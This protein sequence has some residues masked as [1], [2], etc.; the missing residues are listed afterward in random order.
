M[1]VDGTF[2]I[3][4]VYLHQETKMDIDFRVLGSGAQEP[5]CLLSVGSRDW[6][7]GS[8]VI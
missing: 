3:T 5:P 7:V 2:R 8:L 1:Q 4:V 6:E